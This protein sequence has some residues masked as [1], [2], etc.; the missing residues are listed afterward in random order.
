MIYV[1][2]SHLPRIHKVTIA[3]VPPPTE[4]IPFPN[5]AGQHDTTGVTMEMKDI[6]Y[7]II[8]RLTV[9]P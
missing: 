8:C 5:Y 1:G 2:Y 7:Q 9:I 6:H 3:T 4:A